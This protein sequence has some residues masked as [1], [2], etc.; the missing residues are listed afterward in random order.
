MSK[1]II[2]VLGATGAQGGSTV[3]YLLKDGK[4]HIRAFTRN[5]SSD[6]AEKLKQLG[7]EIV[8]GDAKNRDDLVNAFKGAY[9]VFAVT[10][11]WDPEIVGKDV[12]LELTQGKLIVDVA[13][14]QGVKHFIWSS[15]TD[16]EKISGGKYH[17]PHFTQK[18]QIEQYARS[19]KNLPSSFIYLAFY[20]QNI[21]TFFQG[22]KN[23]EGALVF[24]MPI[25]KVRPLAMIDITDTGALVTYMF[26]H[27]DE[28]LGKIVNAA[29]EYITVDK[30]F[31][32]L[33]KFIGKKVIYNYVEPSKN[34]GMEEINHMFAYFNDYG[35]FN[36]GDISE[37]RRMFPQIK[38]WEQYLKANGFNS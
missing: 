14:E 38:T 32:T 31:E 4:Y 7:V 24:T 35:Y 5:P 15:L 19:K 27:R 22:T 10:S 13:E 37:A 1:P 23:A 16:I 28:Y 11:F 17:V 34:Q 3:Q 29:G 36:G 8:K 26:N 9:G 33:G 30:V 21:G 25:D 18:N 6:K 2:T 20:M 12:T